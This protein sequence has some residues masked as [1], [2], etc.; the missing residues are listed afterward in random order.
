[1]NESIIDRL[2]EGFSMSDIMLLFEADLY[3]HQ[4]APG[5]WYKIMHPEKGQVG[6]A[7][8]GSKGDESLVVHSLV[9]YAYCPKCDAYKHPGFEARRSHCEDCGYKLPWTAHSFGPTQI[10]QLIRQ[11]QKIA[12]HVKRIVT[13]SRVTG[14]REKAARTSGRGEVSTKHQHGTFVLR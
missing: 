2:L 7:L 8:V 12:P 4:D 5:G 11:V 14:A 9:A 3:L 10:R 6:H 13:T 1:M